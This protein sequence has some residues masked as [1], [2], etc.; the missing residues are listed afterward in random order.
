MFLHEN[1]GVPNFIQIFYEQVFCSVASKKGPTAVAKQSIAIE[2]KTLLPSSSEGELK[3]VVAGE[4]FKFKSWM[5]HFSHRR[6]AINF[7]S[8]PRIPAHHQPTEPPSSRNP[9]INKMAPNLFFQEI[10]S[11]HPGLVAADIVSGPKR[12]RKNT[13]FPEIPARHPALVAADIVNGP[14]RRRPNSF[15]QELPPPR[16][17]IVFDEEWPKK[18]KKSAA[19]RFR[20]F[21]VRQMM[22]CFKGV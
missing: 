22:C 11:R 1:Q 3:L 15:F 20:K 14:K 8:A 9:D 2:E 16:S 6:S 17:E 4:R 21:A 12:R 10:P 5:Q 13:F 19:R 18:K 7:T